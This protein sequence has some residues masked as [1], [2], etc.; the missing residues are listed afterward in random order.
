MAREVS[1]AFSFYPKDFLSD[2]HQ[3]AM[4]AGA[5]GAYVRLLCHCWL[6]DS[7]PDNVA[8]LARLV[9]MPPSWL[10]RSWPQIAP[11]FQAVNGRLRQKRLDHERLMQRARREHGREA[12]HVRWAVEKLWNRNQGNIRAV[13]VNVGV[14]G[15]QLNRV[16][17]ELN[18]TTA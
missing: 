3:A 13:A 12:A 7:L 16:E 8:D 4:T 1:P 17:N 14:A 11:C 6:D 15:A 10:A 5:C 9:K 2:V 18:N